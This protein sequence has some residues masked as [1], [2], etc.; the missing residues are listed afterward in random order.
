M[1]CEGAPDGSGGWERTYNNGSCYG[2]QW[3]GVPES[4][5]DSG[6][7]NNTPDETPTNPCPSCGTT[8]PPSDPPDDPDPD[9]T[10]KRGLAVTACVIDGGL[11]AVVGGSFFWV[12][13]AMAVTGARLNIVGGLAGTAPW[14]E[15]G[16]GI[17]N[18]AESLAEGKG[19]AIDADFHGGTDGA[20]AARK[21]GRGVRHATNTMAKHDAAVRGWK[22][23]AKGI[24]G[25][26]FLA[27]TFGRF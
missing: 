8:P 23:A 21:A 7:V 22:V 2:W 6:A 3:V 4:Q 26:G 17:F 9:P 18:K 27:D 11:N 20:R 15:F 25:V 24:S 19:L 5:S 14:G 12:G 10:P 16:H 1:T 13:A